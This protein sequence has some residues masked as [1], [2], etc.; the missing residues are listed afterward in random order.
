M[1]RE[2]RH[3]H[4]RPSSQTNLFTTS[5]GITPRDVTEEIYEF[6]RLLLRDA[7]EKGAL[8][9]EDAADL[10]RVGELQIRVDNP[11][12]FF[13]HG[14]NGAQSGV[15]ELVFTFKYRQTSEPLEQEDIHYHDVQSGSSV[16]YVHFKDQD[17]GVPPVSYMEYENGTFEVHEEGKAPQRFNIYDTPFH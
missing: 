4:R 12:G 6:G 14:S 9:V 16:R 1:R 8:N 15:T 3:C 17:S 2:H 5:W 7:Q 13:I 10:D 11:L